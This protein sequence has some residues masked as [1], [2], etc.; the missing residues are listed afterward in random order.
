MVAANL[1]NYMY[2]IAAQL[3]DK[4]AYCTCHVFLLASLLTHM[5]APTLGVRRMTFLICEP[6]KYPRFFT[7]RQRLLWTEVRGCA[8]HACGA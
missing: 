1:Q 3:N 5:S 4:G 2:T 6:E 8:Q 7:Y